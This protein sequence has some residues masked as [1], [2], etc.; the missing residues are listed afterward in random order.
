[1]TI[2]MYSRSMAQARK[3][4]GV[5]EFQE[6]SSGQVA[7]Q[8]SAPISSRRWYVAATEPRKEWLAVLNLEQQSFRSLCPRFHKVRRHA[9]RMETVLAPLFPGYVFVSFDVDNDQ[10]SSIN[11]TLGV[12]RLIRFGP[13]RPQ[14]MPDAAMIQLLGRCRDGIM[15]RLIDDIQAGDAVRIISGPFA[16]Q[17]A[18]VESLD[19]KGRVRVLLDILGGATSLQLG[20]DCLAP[21]TA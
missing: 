4:T 1:M 7:R 3:W 20:I 10:W 21:T 13:T 17:L 2:K 19:D 6:P 16:D 15:I 9:R 14:P 11:G 12:R 8:R 18:K 5:L